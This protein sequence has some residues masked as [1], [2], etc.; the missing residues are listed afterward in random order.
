[1]DERLVLSLPDDCPVV[2][3]PGCSSWEE[4]ERSSREDEAEESPCSDLEAALE[5]SEQGR[6]EEEEVAVHLLPLGFAE[7]GVV[8]EDYAVEVVHT[9]DDYVRAAKVADNGLVSCDLPPWASFEC[10]G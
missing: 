10:V 7:A 8:E 9:V 2:S 4:S 3:F 5:E 6:V 1:M